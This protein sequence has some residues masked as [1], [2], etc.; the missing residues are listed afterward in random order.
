MCKKAFH[1]LFEELFSSRGTK[2]Q[3]VF[4]K[5]KQSSREKIFKNPSLFLKLELSRGQGGLR[6]AA[7][8]GKKCGPE[9]TAWPSRQKLMRPHWTLQTRGMSLLQPINTP[10]DALNKSPCFEPCFLFSFHV[11]SLSEGIKAVRLLFLPSIRQEFFEVKCVLFLF[12]FSFLFF[13]SP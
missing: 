10:N 2:N 11:V 7:S 3:T 5:G 1:Q 12:C 13:F 9:W 4:T 6:P 8:L